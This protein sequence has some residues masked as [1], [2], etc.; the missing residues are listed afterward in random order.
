MCTQCLCPNSSFCVQVP[1][2]KMSGKCLIF[3]D[4]YYLCSQVQHEA[5]M[6]RVFSKYL[7]N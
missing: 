3:E 4:M 2:K 5:G 6:E 7:W 1:Q